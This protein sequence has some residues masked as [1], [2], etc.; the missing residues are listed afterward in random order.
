MSC[1]PAA[2]AK[3]SLPLGP[4]D[5]HGWDVSSWL[6][7][8]QILGGA[9]SILEADLRAQEVD[10]IYLGPASMS[11]SC[12]SLVFLEKHR[13]CG[14]GSRRIIVGAS[15]EQNEGASSLENEVVL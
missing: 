2:W 4:Q 8:R 14:I 6:P 3:A 9:V 13:G 1:H 7:T 11:G 10:K 15:R 5:E 12:L